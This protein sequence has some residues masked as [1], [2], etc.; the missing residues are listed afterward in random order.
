ME[1][2][3]YYLKGF[4]SLIVMIFF[5]AQFC[6]I[7]KE[8]N[9]GAFI[10]ASL[11]EILSSIKLSGILLVIISFLFVFAEWTFIRVMNRRALEPIFTVFTPVFASKSPIAK[12]SQN[13]VFR[14]FCNFMHNRTF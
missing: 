6:L 12:A 9:I 8:T 10:V 11:A 1:G 4:S 14:S 5:A 3:N 13:T 7:F 2:A